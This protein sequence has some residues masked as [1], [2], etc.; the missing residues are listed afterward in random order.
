MSITSWNRPPAQNMTSL[1]ALFF[2]LQPL[3]T[4]S[5]MTEV[6]F[7]SAIFSSQIISITTELRLGW[8]SLH[9]WQTACGSEKA[10]IRL[11]LLLRHEAFPVLT[12]L[13]LLRSVL[14]SL[15]DII[16]AWRKVFHS[17]PSAAHAHTFPPVR[18][19]TYRKNF[20]LVV[21]VWFLLCKHRGAGIMTA[22]VNMNP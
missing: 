12:S 10:F 19:H 4:L 15:C 18:E 20:A 9:C 8:F 6:C 17:F 1:S 5:V 22:S 16:I 7:V 13:Q 14:S 11:L 3:R 21:R 2:I